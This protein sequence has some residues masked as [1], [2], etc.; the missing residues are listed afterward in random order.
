M[1]LINKFLVE[2]DTDTNSIFTCYLLPHL[3]VPHLTGAPPNGVFAFAIYT[4]HNHRVDTTKFSQIV[5][6]CSILISKTFKKSG[7][8]IRRLGTVF[9]LLA[10]M[11][12]NSESKNSTLL[13]N[14]ID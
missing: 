7:L 1:P 8:K 3:Y 2:S 4:G 6:Y 13:D 11:T 14:A 9:N 12:L 10:G 5:T